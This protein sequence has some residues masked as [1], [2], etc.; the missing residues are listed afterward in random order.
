MDSK[1]ESKKSQSK[2][3]KISWNKKNHVEN[4]RLMNCSMYTIIK[5]NRYAIEHP[6]SSKLFEF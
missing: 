5:H 3:I 6:I 4:E 1:I 2:N